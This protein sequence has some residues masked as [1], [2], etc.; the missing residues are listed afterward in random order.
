MV[1]IME[2]LVKRKNTM[3]WEAV[4]SNEG[5]IYTFKNWARAINMLRICYPEETR[6]GSESTARVREVEE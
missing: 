5:K 1:F 6:F 3:V 4:R 2:I